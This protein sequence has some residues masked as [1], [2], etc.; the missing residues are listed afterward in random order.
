MRI[1]SIELTNV[2]G[3]GYQHV[4][5]DDITIIR[6]DNEVGKTTLMNAVDILLTYTS[7]STD[8]H[9]AAIVPKHTDAS[10]E[11][12][13]DMSVGEYRFTYY[14]RYSTRSGVDK[15]E[16]R[17]T[18]PAAMVARTFI[19]R[20]AHDKVKEILAAGT[21]TALWR[22]LWIQQSGTVEQLEL[23]G[24]AGLLQAVDAAAGVAARSEDSDDGERRN[25]TIVD[26]VLKEYLT[27]FTKTKG[28]NTKFETERKKAVA[29][30]EALDA[31]LRREVDVQD[32][33][34]EHAAAGRKLKQI[35]GALTSYGPRVADLE[36]Q[37]AE[38]EQAA[39]NIE[40]LQQTASGAQREADG[41]RQLSQDRIALAERAS[42]EVAAADEAEEKASAMAAQADA[43]EGA[44]DDAELNAAS[45]AAAHA[46]SEAALEQARADLTRIRDTDELTTVG[47]RL[48]RIGIATAELE[49]LH[50]DLVALASIDDS[51]LAAIEAAAVDVATARAVLQASAARLDVEA[52]ADVSVT[53]AVG[54]EERILAGQQQQWTLSGRMTFTVADAVRLTVTPGASEK[55]LRR[56]AE[57]AA[58]KLDRL[59]AAVGVDDPTDARSQLRHRNDLQA[60]VGGVQASI[61]ADL[62]GQ[63]EVELRA[64][65]AQLSAKA[66]I[67]GHDGTGAG[68]RAEAE[69]AVASAELQERGDRDRWQSADAAAQSL[70]ESARK[71]RTEA[72]LAADR[73]KSMADAARTSAEQLELARSKESDAE[74]AERAAKL[75]E[76][77]EERNSAWQQAVDGYS[78]E[79]AEEVSAQ[80]ET[81]RAAIA[82]AENQRRQ[83]ED[84][85]LRTDTLLQQA[86]DVHEAVADAQHNRDR[87]VGDYEAMKARAAAVKMLHEALAT[88]RAAARDAYVA[89]YKARLEELAQIAFGRPVILELDKHLAVASRTMDGANVEFAAL[90]GG[91]KEQLAVCA[92]LAFGSLVARDDGHVPVI[93]DDA[94][95]YTDD[96]RMENID[97][98][99]NV[100]RS[101]CQVIILTCTRTRYAG[102]KDAETIELNKQPVRQL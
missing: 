90:S 24:R 101:R 89:P 12:R 80:L 72:L 98:V 86:G 96:D 75:A 45:L 77:A 19:A 76:V 5:L 56:K 74:L 60:K 7:N 34:N 38:F 50:R 65:A 32:W 92:R 26:A 47:R 15:T 40:A 28:P 57:E 102:V 78:S 48:E 29:A 94:L 25:T 70:R 87:I 9:V 22:A 85:R 82:S 91:A 17:F 41:V 30:E 21:D 81:V 95:G 35:A 42:R 46:A 67:A 88:Y 14:K 33:V 53:D 93:I 10:P 100:A 63:T 66:N 31:A 2:A 61:T 18:E 37:C 6:G 54:D 83:L 69:Q 27:Y 55:D 58:S 1:H 11:I 8:R 73:V 62:D 39:D 97:R 84:L 20:E 51:A 44:A 64:L 52:L 16:L 68:S 49:Q 59:C 71:N 4:E 13:V 3:T 79:K 99:F 43:A 23:D 36:L